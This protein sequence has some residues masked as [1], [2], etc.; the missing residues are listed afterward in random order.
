MCPPISPNPT[1]P[2]LGLGLGLGLGIGQNGAEPSLV[3]VI[4]GEDI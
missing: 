4:Y 1:A 3:I 2:N